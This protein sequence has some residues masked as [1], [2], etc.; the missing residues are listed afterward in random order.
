MAH[1]LSASLRFGSGV[2]VLL[3][4]SVG[5]LICLGGGPATAQQLEPVTRQ[6]AI[7]SA[8]AR[9]PRVSIA[10]ADTAL[11]RAEISVARAWQNPI[12]TA[13]YTKSVPQRHLTVEIP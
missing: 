7:A 10:F 2:Q 12:V 1:I 11:A 3:A 13:E 5:G 8:L 4:L 6:Q 9:G